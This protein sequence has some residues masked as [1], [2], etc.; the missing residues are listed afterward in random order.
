MTDQPQEFHLKSSVATMQLWGC[1]Q[2]LYCEVELGTR[3]LL[4]VLD[5]A[6]CCPLEGDKLLQVCSGASRIPRSPSP[7]WSSLVKD[8]ASRSGVSSFS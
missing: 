3:M 1:P 2:K 4:L 7:S 6:Y 8:L 5:L